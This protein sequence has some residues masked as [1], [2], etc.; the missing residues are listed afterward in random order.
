[1]QKLFLATSSHL[2]QCLECSLA[3]SHHYNW[4]NHSINGTA[5]G[6]SWLSYRFS[7]I[8]LCLWR[9]N[10][11]RLLRHKFAMRVNA[12]VFKHIITLDIHVCSVW[13]WTFILCTNMGWKQCA[14]DG[15]RPIFLLISTMFA[16][17]INEIYGPIYLSRMGTLN[18]YVSS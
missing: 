1:M 6:Y 3:H 5:C 17:M 7:L 12:I 15:A 4:W 14:P 8:S 2:R 11:K 13:L 18:D 9:E 16:Y 10:G